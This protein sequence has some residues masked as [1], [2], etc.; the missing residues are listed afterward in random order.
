LGYGP[1]G[2]SA[3]A[4]R[5]ACGTYVDKVYLFLFYLFYFLRYFGIV[6]DHNW[7]LI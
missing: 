6:R 3:L 5:Y 1:S 4:A 2:K 7:R